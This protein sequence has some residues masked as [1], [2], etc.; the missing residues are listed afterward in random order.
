MERHP[1]GHTSSVAHTSVNPM[2][3][4]VAKKPRVP[5]SSYRRAG[6]IVVIVPG[7]KKPA[8]GGLRDQD[9]A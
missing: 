4:R 5:D 7:E 6:M 1:S 3:S 9:G 8:Y 2:G